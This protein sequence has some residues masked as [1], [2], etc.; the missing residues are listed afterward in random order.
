MRRGRNRAW[1]EDARRRRQ[2]AERCTHSAPVRNV[3]RK[4]P[5]Y[6]G[7]LMN[8]EVID[9]NIIDL[10]LQ[11]EDLAVSRRKI[12]WNSSR[13]TLAPI[14]NALTKL[15][16]EPRIDGTDLNIYFSGDKHQLAAVIRILRTSGFNTDEK[17]PEKGASS[18]TARFTVQGCPLPI[19]LSFCSSVC[20]QVQVGTKTVEIPIYET[21]CGEV[22]NTDRIGNDAVGSIEQVSAELLP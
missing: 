14:V 8:L 11:E 1:L 13:S 16:I 17:R 19:Y 9:E 20:R 5:Y 4:R 3:P 15:G 22:E 12:R 6:D 10:Q 2:S 7:V 18:W 21:V